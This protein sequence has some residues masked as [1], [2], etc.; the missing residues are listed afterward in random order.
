MPSKRSQT[1]ESAL[2]AHI[3]ARTRG[4]ENTFPRVIAGPGHDCAVVATPAKRLLLK[5]D[6]LIEG[7]H[8]RKGTPLTLIAR[9]AVARTISDIAASGGSPWCA[10]VAAAVPRGFKEAAKLFDLML[11]AGE[12]FSCPVV[13]GDIAGTSGPLSLAVTVVEIGRAHV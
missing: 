11:E 8:F 5:V 13:G 7:K 1:S 2:L 10:M 12:S 6:Q 9:K 3:I 4:M